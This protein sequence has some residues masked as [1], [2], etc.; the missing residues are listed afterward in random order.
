MFQVQIGFGGQLIPEPSHPP[1]GQF[2]QAN[3]LQRP[4]QGILDLTEPVL[5]LPL[6][7]SQRLAFLDDGLPLLE[8]HPLD[9]PHLPVLEKIPDLFQRH[10]QGSEIPDG[11]QALKLPGAVGPVA[12][13]GVHILRGEQADLLIVPQGAHTH[14]EHPGHLSNGEPLSSL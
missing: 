6:H 1:G 9:L 14:P 5:D 10:L 11:V 13:G 12:C 7:D 4:F 8:E 3:L 2:H